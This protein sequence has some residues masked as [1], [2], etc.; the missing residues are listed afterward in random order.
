MTEQ[1][2]PKPYE[3]ARK[4]FDELSSYDDPRCSIH[5]QQGERCI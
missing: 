3:A 1:L 4:R 2:D 5:H